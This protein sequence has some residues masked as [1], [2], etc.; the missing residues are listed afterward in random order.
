MQRHRPAHD[1]QRSVIDLVMFEAQFGANCEKRSSIF[2]SP[3]CIFDEVGKFRP[4]FRLTLFGEWNSQFARQST[5]SVVNGARRPTLK[6][7]GP[8]ERSE[9]CQPVSLQSMIGLIKPEPGCLFTESSKC[10]HRDCA[11]KTHEL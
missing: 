3:I 2:S 11:K 9:E 5:R 8:A 4:N 6:S 10:I 1:H 7:A